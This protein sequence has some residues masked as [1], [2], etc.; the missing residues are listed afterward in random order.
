MTARISTDGPRHPLAVQAGETFSSLVRLDVSAQSHT[1]HH[2]AN[3]EDHFLVARLGRTLQTM[4]TSLPAGAVP[5]RTEE[6]IPA[7]PSMTSRT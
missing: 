5:E 1:G 2:R 4:I 7:L 6:S 3:N